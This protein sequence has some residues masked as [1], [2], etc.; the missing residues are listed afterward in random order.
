M[1]VSK[2]RAGEGSARGEF[3]PVCPG[4][5]PGGDWC[6][7]LMTGAHYRRFVPL[8]NRIAKPGVPNPHMPSAKLGGT[9]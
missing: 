6:S 3:I 2:K 9:E 8:A 4:L 7:V 1:I 5:D